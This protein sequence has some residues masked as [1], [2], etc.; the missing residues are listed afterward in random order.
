MK[1]PAKTLQIDSKQYVVAEAQGGAPVWEVQA[2]Q[3]LEK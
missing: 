1:V 2:G 3:R